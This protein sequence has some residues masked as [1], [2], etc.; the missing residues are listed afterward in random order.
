[1]VVSALAAKVRRVLLWARGVDVV[2]RVSAVVAGMVL[3][4]VGVVLDAI[5]ASV[6]LR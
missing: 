2:L 6:Q 5:S 1:M 4:V 3:K